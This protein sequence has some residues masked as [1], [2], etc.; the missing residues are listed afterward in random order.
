M[1]LYLGVGNV[2][3]AIFPQSIVEHVFVPGALLLGIE[4]HEDIDDT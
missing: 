1:Y 3:D 2:N 4:E